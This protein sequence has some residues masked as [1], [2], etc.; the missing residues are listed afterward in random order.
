[1][2]THLK[3]ML[4]YFVLFY[5]VEFSKEVCSF[6]DVHEQTDGFQRSTTT[7][8]HVLRIIYNA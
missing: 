3:K 6:R 8:I 1:M 7:V 5:L 4:F 2:L